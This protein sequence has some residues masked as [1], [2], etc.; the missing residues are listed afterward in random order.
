MAFQEPF[1]QYRLLTSKLGVEHG[2]VAVKDE[3]SAARTFEG[4]RS[5]GVADQG[6]LYGPEGNTPIAYYGRT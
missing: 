5:A 2:S 4:L 6:A 3:A 1:F